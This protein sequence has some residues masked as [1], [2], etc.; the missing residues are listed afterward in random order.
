MPLSIGATYR[1]EMTVRLEAVTY[2]AHDPQAAAVFWAEMLGRTT[3][4]EGGAVLVPGDA[5]QVGLR[6]VAATPGNSGSE[7]LHLHVTS[8]TPEDQQHALDDVLRLGGRRRGTGALPM[9]R[10]LYMA[11]PDGNEFCLI[12]PGNAYLADCGPLGEVT[13][14]GGRATGLF[15][16]D[17]L[18]W[19]LVWD[20]GEQT[21][22][23]SPAGGTKIAWDLSPDTPTTGRTRQ[24]FDL[25]AADPEAEAERL[26]GLG[27]ASRG[28]RDGALLFADPDGME[29][30]IRQ[31]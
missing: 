27:A 20:E 30:S 2:D 14:E 21:A 23:Q 24:R 8:D 15:W 22:I 6:F 9:G 3:V 31:G 5:T 10:D 26:V 13:C 18:A 1:G 16:R 29:F 19:M 25:L 12:E 11:D 17:A 4:D 7:R 28:E